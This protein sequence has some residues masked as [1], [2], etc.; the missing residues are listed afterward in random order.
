MLSDGVIRRVSADEETAQNELRT[1]QRHLESAATLSGSDPNAA[2]QLA[3]DAARKAIAAHMRANGYRVGS[4][5]G[6]HAKTGQYAA[7]A[8]GE[9]PLL[10][11]QARRGDAV[12]A[13]A[14]GLRPADERALHAQAEPAAR[15]APRRFRD[16]LLAPGSSRASG[17]GALPSFAYDELVARDKASLDITWLRD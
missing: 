1:A 16:M 12:D 17:V 14:V 15:G 10:R 7:A 9:R 5:E 4:G 13:R 6:A 11:P 8:L 2:F 3:Y